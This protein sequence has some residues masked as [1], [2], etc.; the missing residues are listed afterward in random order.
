MRISSLSTEYITASVTATVAG[1]PI[2]VT[3]DVVAWAMVTP[4]SDPVT[5][6]TGDWAAGNAR[7]LV[8]PSGAAPLGK[9]V[10]DVW[11]KVTD[12]PEVPVRLIGQLAVD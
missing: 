7:I 4:G 11:L 1:V 5:W 10:W 3:G 9:G 6:I 8:G 2:D 12:S